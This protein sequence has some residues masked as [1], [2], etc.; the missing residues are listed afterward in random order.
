MPQI[1]TDTADTHKGHNEQ[2]PCWRELVA[3]AYYIC[4]AIY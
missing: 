1:I 3:R 2:P 4:R